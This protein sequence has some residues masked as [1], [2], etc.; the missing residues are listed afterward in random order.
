Y[1]SHVSHKIEGAAGIEYGD[2]EDIEN[3]EGMEN[4]SDVVE[5]EDLDDKSVDS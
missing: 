5:V 3:I 2:K 4:K 1:A